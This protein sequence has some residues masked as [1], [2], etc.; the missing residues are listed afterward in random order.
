MEAIDKFI[1]AVAAMRA[2]QKQ[3]FTTRSPKA[4]LHAKFF[5]AKVDAYLNTLHKGDEPPQLQMF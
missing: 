1:I 2:A 4:L 3:Y 5:E